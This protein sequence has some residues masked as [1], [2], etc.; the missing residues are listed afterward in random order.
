MCILHLINVQAGGTHKG[1]L[2]TGVILGISGA[3]LVFLVVTGVLGL[4]LWRRRQHGLSPG[5]IELLVP[6][7]VE[8][9]PTLEHQDI[10]LCK[11]E[12]GTDWLLGA[13]SY[14]QVEALI[15]VKSD[16]VS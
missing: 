10:T 16:I 5:S 7:L 13:G 11:H 12:D 1:R 3:L 4:L 6:R 2:S 14:G 8:G 9:F 15:I